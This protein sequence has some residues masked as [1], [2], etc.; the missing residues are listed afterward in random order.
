MLDPHQMGAEGEQ[1][2]VSLEAV[3]RDGAR[4][5]AVDVCWRNE[6]GSWTDR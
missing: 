2:F 3:E 4:C 5:V 1:S 6:N